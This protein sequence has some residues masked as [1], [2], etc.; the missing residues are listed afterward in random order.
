MSR[1]AN[2]GSTVGVGDLAA[3]TATQQAQLIRSGQVSPVEVVD[4]VF[5]R[6]AALEPLVHAFCHLDIAPALDHARAAEAAV[7]RGDALG[8]LHGVPISV[9]DLIC[10]ADMPTVSGSRAYVGFIPEEDDVCVER[11]RAAGAIVIGK[12]NTPEFGYAGAGKNAVFASTANP[13]NTAMTSGGSSA[14]SAAAVAAGMGSL[15]IGSDGGGSIRGPASYCGLFGLKPSY[16]RVPAYPGCRDPRYPGVSSWE[17]VEHLGPL[18][19]TVEDASLLMS[20]IAGP[21]ARDWHSLPAGDVDWLAAPRAPL[22]PLRIAFT[23][24]FGFS[25]VDPEV[26]AITQAAAQVFATDLGCEVVDDTPVLEDMF[27]VFLAIIMRDSDLRGLRD[28]AG[29]GLIHLPGLLMMLERDWTGQDFTDAAMARQ[30]VCNELRRF[31]QGYDLL[32]TPTV[33]SPPFSVED[34]NPDAI[35][36]IP[37]QQANASPFTY[38]FNWTGQPAAS[39][40]AGF[41]GSGLP[42]GLQIV[43]RHL[44]D[45]LVLTAAAA[46]ERARPWAQV[47][48]SLC[49]AYHIG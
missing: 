29:Q 33:S 47:W 4:A 40:P 14:G 1:L 11:V 12:T 10:T 34:F 17:S 7:L 24:D 46:F 8:P 31:M 48:P 15:S 41:T 43:G 26:R 20:V 9:K 16:G 37:A 44:A 35:G 39:V 45:G 3:L 18:T 38:P 27:D 6:I 32:L 42:V 2:T 21:D 22:P 5:A 23:P 13:W 49:N 36:A 19:R 28:L 25:A 30:R